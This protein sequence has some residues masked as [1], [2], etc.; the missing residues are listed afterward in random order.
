MYF[1]EYVSGELEK[2]SVP[3][4]T[5]TALYIFLHEKYV[6][7]MNGGAVITNLPQEF[8][9]LQF[10]RVVRQLAKRNVISPDVEFKSAVWQNLM[11]PPAATA[12]DAFCLVDPYAYIAYL[13]A[14][15]WYGFT[16]RSA[17]ELQIVSLADSMWRKERINHLKTEIPIGLIGTEFP[18]PHRI[19]IRKTLRGRKIDFHK[20]THPLEMVRVR[21][22][23][24]R[25]T[26]KGSTFVS[27]LSEPQ[28]C[29]GMRHVIEVF[30]ENYSL[31]SV[32]IVNS[33]EKFGSDIVKVRAG[34]IIDELIKDGDEDTNRWLKLA[35]RG[36]SRKLDPQKPYGTSFSEKWMIATNV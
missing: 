13:S 3:L 17:T 20:T 18:M 2:L 19:G 7:A 32:E 9:Y 16:N 24:T 4:L 35:Q 14:M 26:T 8:G 1:A 36:G 11:V 30:K 12:E 5:E 22:T 29:G 31:N 6:N 27:M 10:R 33:I 25:I 15:Q 23:H 34:Y 28:Y 21:G